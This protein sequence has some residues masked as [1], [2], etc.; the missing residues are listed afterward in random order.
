MHF[1]LI[2]MAIQLIWIILSFCYEGEKKKM[3]N[4]VGSWCRKTYVQC[5]LVKYTFEMVSTN[6]YILYSKLLFSFVERL[7]HVIKCAVRQCW[8]GSGSSN[9]NRTP[10]SQWHPFC[11]MV[12]EQNILI[13]IH[14]WIHPSTIILSQSQRLLL[15]YFVYTHIHIHGVIQC[16]NQKSL[17]E[18]I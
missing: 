2:W 7:W 10:F 16:A 6:M 14:T 13:V 1:T 18:F 4:T 3:T 9:C 8:R 15:H 12:R 11:L 17:D 5:W